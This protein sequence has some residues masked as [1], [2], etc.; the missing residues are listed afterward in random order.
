MIKLEQLKDM[1]QNH[2]LQILCLV[3]MEPPTN[4]NSESIRDEK[5]KVSAITEAS[6]ISRNERSPVLLVNI[7]KAQ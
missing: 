3:A 5:L 1:L 6:Q 4:I 7:K 2:L